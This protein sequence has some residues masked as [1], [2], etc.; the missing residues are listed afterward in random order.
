MNY[1]LLVVFWGIYL[2]L[3][4][5]LAS[6]RCKAFFKKHIPGVVKYY[7]LLYSGFSTIGLIIILIQNASESTYLF[8]QTNSIKYLSLV[9][10]A[11]GVIVIRM[12]FKSYSLKS[13]LGFNPETDSF[14]ENGV[15]KHIRHPIYSGTILIVVGFFLFSPT[16]S[17]LVSMICVFTYLPFGIYLEERKLV[18]MFGDKYISYKK[19]VPSIF[20]ALW[21]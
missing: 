16:M 3:H 9:I 19:R 10:T 11:F 1:I 2:F 18:S 13:F 7:R 21:K 5:F 20:P 4:S 6:F 14:S 12:A 15:L 8:Y 17:T